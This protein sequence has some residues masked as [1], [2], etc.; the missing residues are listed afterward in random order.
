MI[1]KILRRDIVASAEIKNIAHVQNAMDSCAQ[2]FFK[3]GAPPHI[4]V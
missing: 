4:P 1:A 2:I 3:T